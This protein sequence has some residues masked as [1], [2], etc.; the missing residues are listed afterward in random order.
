MTLKRKI[1]CGVA[2]LLATTTV[3][4]ELVGARGGRQP[5]ARGQRQV[6]A[7]PTQLNPFTLRMEP[8][9]NRT[10]SGRS[11]NRG[12]TRAAQVAR[13]TVPASRM[14]TPSRRPRR[15]PYKRPRRGGF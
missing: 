13:V 5:A 1:L 8:V 6:V 14:R 4:V 2:L 10:P 9:S 15:S 3:G 11:A 7:S 12:R